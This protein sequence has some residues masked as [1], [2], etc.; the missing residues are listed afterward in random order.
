LPNLA[1]TL[2]D[3][4]VSHLKSLTILQLGTMISDFLL[5]F[6][7]YRESLMDKGPWALAN[8]VQIGDAQGEGATLNHPLEGDSQQGS[9]WETLEES[10]RT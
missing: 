9:Y 1:L 3:F 4:F 8:K 7:F 10:T 5:T 6:I 2:S